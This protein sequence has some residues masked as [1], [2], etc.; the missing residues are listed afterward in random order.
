MQRAE[1]RADH[2]RDLVDRAD[3]DRD[4]TGAVGC[5]RHRRVGEKWL[6]AKYAL[7]LRSSELRAHATCFELQKALYHTRSSGLVL[8][9][10]AAH[11]M[12]QRAG[13]AERGRPLWMDRDGG[14][15]LAVART[16]GLWRGGECGRVLRMQRGREDEQGE[17][18]GTTGRAHGGYERPRVS[19]HSAVIMATSTQNFGCGPPLLAERIELRCTMTRLGIE[20]RT[21]G[22]KDRRSWVQFQ[23]GHVSARRATRAP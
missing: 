19:A 10:H 16:H 1:R 13:P 20:P 15:A 3:I 4:P 7:G 21:Y 11:D 9:Q 18:D 2:E 23:W 17:A 22:L 12:S 8:H 14:D 5:C 6:R